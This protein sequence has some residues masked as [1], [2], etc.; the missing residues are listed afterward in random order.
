[1]GV[2]R[3][4]IAERSQ[5][6]L[7]VPVLMGIGI[8]VYFAL[9]VEPPVWTVALPVAALAAWAGLRRAG[10]AAAIAGLVALWIAVGFALAVWRAHEV[11][12]PVLERAIE[13]TVEGRVLEV[14]RAPSGKLRLLLDR[15]VIHGMAPGDWPSRVRITVLPE[16]DAAP[17]RPGARVM[18]LARLIPPGG[19]VEPGGFDFRRM[20]WFDRLGA[21]GVARGL[22][23]EVDPGPHGGAL[24][25]ARLTL[26]GWRAELAEALRRALPGETGSFASAILIGDRSGI[27]EEAAEALR[28]SNL[29]HLLAISGLH[30]GLLT[31]FV[32]L[33][34]RGGLALIPPVALRFPVKRIA[35]VAAICAGLAYLL[36]SGAAV[37]TQRSF[38]MVLVMFCAVLID[39]PAISMRSIGLAAVI[40]LAL[41]PE[42]MVEVGF[43][44]SF[45]ATVALVAVWEALRRSGRSPAGK[46]LLRGAAAL[47]LT[48]TVAGFATAP[49]S[50]YTFHQ[51]GVYGLPA[52]LIAVPLMGI[53]IMPAGA[54]AGPLALVGLEGP[55]LWAMGL[56]IDLVME[57]ARFFTA[58]PGSLA[59][60][61]EPGAPVLVPIALGG[62]WLC[63]WQGRIRLAGI[64]AIALGLVWWQVSAIRPELLV[65]ASGRQ[66]GLMGP[67]GRAVF[68]PR[69]E[70]WTFELWL[71]ADGDR[72]DIVAAAARP[73]LERAKDRA[74]GR[75]GEWRVEVVATPR[76]DAAA[77][78]GLCA[79]KVLLIA[80]GLR[81]AP[82]GDCLAVTGDSLRRTGALA[83][84]TD[85]AALSIRTALEEDARL[86]TRSRSGD[87]PED[88]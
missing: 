10:F 33:V 66:I 52:N 42:S 22:V 14:S 75:L 51:T 84:R 83:I 65:A 30:M 59:R 61:A 53:W 67:E 6:P 44:M 9:P 55:A 13:M 25:G 77:L 45:A 82:S 19:P 47:A 39:R 40:I 1:M 21:A 32:F 11:A 48:S 8:A 26:A 85:G 54:L 79:E 69:R 58:L 4:L 46:G 63:L 20:A 87:P 60:I 57:I 2:E 76:P 56:G 7:W 24:D 50:A 27:P 5:L 34:L 16:D 35:A 18:T 12:A 28:V 70:T 36:L 68:V 88:R 49:I 74:T 38:I 86:W 17:F 71:E 31:G 72:P 29:A 43:Q 37:A 62:L 23:L 81:D 41:F 80:P 78:R 3:F 64:V 73:G 15:V